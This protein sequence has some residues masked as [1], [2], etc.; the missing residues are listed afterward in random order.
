MPFV[1]S[2]GS[3]RAQTRPGDGQQC[4][5]A[6]KTLSGSQLA[7]ILHGEQTKCLSRVALAVAALITP[8][9]ARAATNRK[10]PKQQLHEVT[11]SA[12]QLQ[13]LATQKSSIQELTQPIIDTPQAI[14]T[15]SRK[16]LSDRGV[17]N[18]NEALRMVPGISLGAGETSWQGNNLYLRGF[19]TRDD[20]FVDGQRDYGYYYRDPFDDEKI[21]VLEGPSSILFGRGTT[22]GVIN[23]VS[24]TPTL[25]QLASATATLGSAE[26]RRVT[27]DV[28]SPISWL[29]SGAAFRLNVMGHHSKTADRDGGQSDRWGNAPSLALGLG[30]PTRF[31]INY[32]HETDNEVPDYGIPWFDGRPTPVNSANFYGFS[33]DYLD[34]VVN[35]VTM[36]FE[37]D[38]SESITLTSQARYSYDT[39]RFRTSEA[40]V[41]KGTLSTTPIGEITVSRNEFEGFSTDKFAQ[42]QTTVVDRFATGRISHALVGGLEFGSESPNPTYITN[43]GVPGTNLAN[44][45]PEAYSATESYPALVASTVAETA[46]VYALDTAQWRQ[47]QLM[48][49]VRWDRFAANY[50][51]TNYSPQGAIIARNHVYQHNDA[52][53][54]RG[55][56]VYTL[57]KRGSIYLAAGTSFDPSAEGIESVV[58]SGRALA[59]ANEN[60]APEKNRSY[61]LGTKLA[62]DHQ[63]VVLTASI[64]RLEKLNA[65]VP[66]PADPQFDILGGDQRVDGA[67]I[68]A[69]GNL[70][71][72]WSVR[73]SYS[74]LDSKVIR[75]TPGGPLLGAPLTTTPLNSSAFWSEYQLSSRVLVGLGA[76][77]ASSRLGQDTASSYEV[78]PGY[79]VLDAM[80][81][82]LLWP[83]TSL[84]LNLDNLANRVYYDQLH[85]FHVVPG[86]GFA[87]QLS[88]TVRR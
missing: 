35:A 4:G 29:G 40:V 85:P 28:D 15:L 9:L 75:S 65:R 19:T 26:M 87:V 25:D 57:G 49:G 16:N 71:P 31:W 2:I 8:V 61:E 5:T 70:T 79:V 53:S 7:R 24:K 34:T 50:H 21:E 60:L 64:F 41:P 72:S 58:S 78:A 52:F 37:H 83:S 32:L 46:G 56:L 14:T 30:T 59:T 68:E 18:L 67:Q 47:W 73:T 42:L 12:A 74:Y 86:A 81:K 43:V 66:D 20:M 76:V 69:V 80:A 10:P 1:R 62:F 3:A 38:F 77:Q 51:G 82:Y 36:R 48:A 63:M 13:G 23:E 84:Q 17:A 54:Y 33:N 22:G 44:P 88:L 55:A 6:A 39:R 11:V 27:A 45:Q